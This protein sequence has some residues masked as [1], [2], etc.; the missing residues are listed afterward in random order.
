MSWGIV[1]VIA[2]G[3]LSLVGGILG[4][5]KARSKPSL[6]SGLVSGFLLFFAA[7][8]ES[9]GYD[10]GR[11]LA[12]FIILVLVG[13]FGVRFNQSKKFMPAGLM[14]ST[15]VFCLIILSFF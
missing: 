10:L 11:P 5:L 14:L 1:V 8:L 12:Q 3:I 13:V 9:Q 2:Y 4:Y 6:I 15:G 7:F